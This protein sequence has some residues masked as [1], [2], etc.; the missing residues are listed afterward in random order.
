MKRDH[1]TEVTE[2]K[3]RQSAELEKLQEKLSQGVV[4]LLNKTRD[5]QAVASQI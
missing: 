5:Q 2:L 4:E 3:A 1:E